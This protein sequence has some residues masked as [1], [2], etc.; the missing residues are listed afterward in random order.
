MRWIL[1]VLPTVYYLVLKPIKQFFYAFFLDS[2]PTVHQ[3]FIHFPRHSSAVGESN[4][5]MVEYRIIDNIS[6]WLNF[7][8]SSTLWS[9][10][11]HFVIVLQSLAVQVAFQFIGM[12]YLLCRAEQECEKMM[13]W[14]SR[15]AW[16]KFEL[17]L[18]SGMAAFSLSFDARS[19][20]CQWSQWICCRRSSFLRSIEPL[21]YWCQLAFI[22]SR[23]APF[24]S[25]CAVL[26]C[27]CEKHESREKKEGELARELNF[28]CVRVY[29][30]WNWNRGEPKERRRRSSLSESEIS[31]RDSTVRCSSFPWQLINSTVFA[32]A[33]WQAFLTGSSSIVEED[34]GT[35]AFSS[36]FLLF[37]LGFSYDNLEMA[38]SCIMSS[39]F[40]FFLFWVV[41]CS[42]SQ[43][44]KK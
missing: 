14:G 33:C 43:R 22:Q 5:H 41:P 36:L 32:L 23:R 2:Q 31:S 28:T 40:L 21:P 29:I 20:S 11:L 17:S 27:C 35:T 1:V 6:Q 16:K 26:C 15:Q 7:Q 3:K 12:K 30:L 34:D 42:L 24:Y 19:Q 39:L 18:I 44:V 13:S 38:K 8:A 9:R 37:I 10:Q 4:F 25:L